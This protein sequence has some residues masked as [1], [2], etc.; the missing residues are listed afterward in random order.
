MPLLSCGKKSL[1]SSKQQIVQHLNSGVAL[2]MK[3]FFRH[4]EWVTKSASKKR[5]VSLTS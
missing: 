2:E 5:F 4:I 3:L 1:A